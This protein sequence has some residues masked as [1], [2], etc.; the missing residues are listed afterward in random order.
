LRRY[1]L[2]IGQ[3]W[4]EDAS[5]ASEDYLRNRLR[6]WL[7]DEPALHSALIDLADT[8]RELRQW[9][10]RQAPQLPEA[11]QTQELGGLPDVLAHESARRWLMLRGAPPDEITEATLDRL[12]EMS[13]DAGT[14]AR[15]DFPGTVRVRR[16]GGMISAT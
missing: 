11:F 12:L 16:R 10:K 4:R 6:A 7:A 8:C 15:G 5:N 3:T 2:G 13:R 1:L 9:T 14:A